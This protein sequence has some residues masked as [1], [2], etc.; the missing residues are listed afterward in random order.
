MWSSVQIWLSTEAGSKNLED[1]STRSISP[2]SGHG[3]S[4]VMFPSN[5]I[6]GPRRGLSGSFA[7]TS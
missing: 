1:H 5:Q 6:A 7:R 3:R 4:A 2:V